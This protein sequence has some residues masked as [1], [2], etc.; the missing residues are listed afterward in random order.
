MSNLDV[1]L[2]LWTP[3]LWGGY[4]VVFT[5]RDFTTKILTINAHKRLSL[6][7]HRFRSEIWTPVNYPIDA[8]VNGVSK[9]I[10]PG[11]NQLVPANTV[12]RLINDSDHN[13]QVVEI[14]VGKYDEE[15]IT[16]IDDDWNR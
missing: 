13:V 15:D 4:E 16:R 5:S 7:V 8:I 14:M 11:E 10:L 1:E 6:Q 12:H 2:N 3:T 9:V